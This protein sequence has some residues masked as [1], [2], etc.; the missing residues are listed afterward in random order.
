M[1]L[2]GRIMK[3]LFSI[4]LLTTSSA[5]AAQSDEARALI[6][7]HV[8]GG[9]V[10]HLGCGD[11][12]FLAELAG[13]NPAFVGHGLDADAEGRVDLIPQSD[14]ALRVFYD[15]LEAQSVADAFVRRLIEGI[16]RNID[17]V[18]SGFDQLRWRFS[19]SRLALVAIFTVRTPASL[20]R[21]TL[22]WS[23]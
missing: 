16:Y 1:E 17:L 9:L 2:L 14:E 10:V 20:R 21:R 5:S 13:S 8:S 12:V 23:R 19:E 7:A 4:L 6:K 22:S 11:G 15:L 3:I 18:Q